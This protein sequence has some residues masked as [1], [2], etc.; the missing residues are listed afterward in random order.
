MIRSATRPPLSGA[1]GVRLPPVIY[2]VVVLIVA[3]VATSAALMLRA[4]SL[5][6]A[7]SGG[8]VD[9]PPPPR[10]G[11]D[12]MYRSQH[13]SFVASLDTWDAHLNLAVPDAITLAP[14][15]GAASM[16]KRTLVVYAYSH[17]EWRLHNLEY[18]L[19]HG[20]V[21]HT[22]DGADVDYTFVMNGFDAPVDAFRRAGVKYTL[23]YV[24][25]GASWADV[26][27][28][29]D[30]G[31]GGGAG[32]VGSGAAPRVHVVV[33]EN[34]GYDM[35]ASKL[36]LERGLAARPGTYTHVIL[37]N[38]SVRGPFLPNYV[39]F[40]WI[41]AFQH[42]LVGGVRLVGTTIN[43]LSSLRNDAAGFTSLH[44]QSMVLAL[45][46]AGVRA[47]QPVLQCYEVMTEA[48]SHGEI[49]TTQSVL[50][51]GYG[52]AALQGSWNGFPIFS[53]DLASFEVAR[54]C[55]AVSESTGG[56]PSLPG[57]YLGGEPQ[58]L[59]VIFVKTNR[60][61]DEALLRH[62]TQLRELF[63]E[64]APREERPLRG[65]GTAAR[66]RA[67][68]RRGVRAGDAREAGAA[69]IPRKADSATEFHELLRQASARSRQQP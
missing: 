68:A 60:N 55:A 26:R 20:L 25:K 13:A 63:G 37:M 51:A 69:P 41:D 49:G 6:A 1:C 42:L 12:D 10:L 47:M 59:E 43:C 33:R 4:R 61:L 44:L 8:T 57:A 2:I 40:T 53:A 7:V 48:I 38:G 16:P 15:D 35:C 27:P 24:Q 34:V 18:F 11:R 23:S 56:D 64:S 17:A 36:V 9:G 21:A 32:A 39:S 62:E 29:T 28:L 5:P 31:D 50:A 54:R 3:V 19:L 46:A 30:N 67:A 52:V 45:D 14:A 66:A 22:S 58:P 65:G